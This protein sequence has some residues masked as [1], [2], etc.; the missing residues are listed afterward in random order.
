LSGAAETV[1]AHHERF[2][3][4]GYWQGVVGTRIPPGAGTFAVADNVSALIS[5]RPHRSALSLA[6]A[7]PKIVRQSGKQI[8]LKE[9]AVFP[10]M[11]VDKWEELRSGRAGPKMWR[12]P[13]ATVPLSSLLTKAPQI[14]QAKA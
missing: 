6:A 1:L 7:R 5:D 12:D 9:I 2:D 8:D 11:D 14:L 13:D 4:K 10:P 3:G